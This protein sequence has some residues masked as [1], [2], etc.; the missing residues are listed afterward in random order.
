MGDINGDGIADIV[1]A[2]PGNAPGSSVSVIYGNSTTVRLF[3]LR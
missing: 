1:I 2:S 3:Q